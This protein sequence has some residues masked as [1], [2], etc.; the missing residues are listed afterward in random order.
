MCV[1]DT[2]YRDGLTAGPHYF[3]NPIG[4]L[5]I[6]TIGT[7]QAEIGGVGGDW[8]IYY[9]GKNVNTDAKLY[10]GVDFYDYTMTKPSDQYANDVVLAFDLRKPAFDYWT[11]DSGGQ[12]L[13]TVDGTITK[14]NFT[15]R[16]VGSH[17]LRIE[18]NDPNPCY[19]YLDSGATAWDVTKWGSE[20]TIPTLNFYACFIQY[21]GTPKVY[22]SDNTNA[23]KTDYYWCDITPNNLAVWEHHSIPIGP[24]WGN[25]EA[26]LIDKWGSVSGS[27]APYPQWSHI[28]TIEFVFD[29]SGP[30][31]DIRIDDLH[32]SGKCVREAVHTA[33]VTAY[34]EYQHVILSRTPLDDSAVAADDSGMAGQLCHAELLRRINPPRYFSC[35]VPFKPYLKPGECFTV[36]AGKTTAGAYK[37]S[38]V[39]FRVVE[40]THRVTQGFQPQT[41]LVMT[42]DVLNS[43]P[44]GAVNARGVLNEYLLEN[45]KKATDM[46]GGEVD[47]LIPHLRKTY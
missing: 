38:G 43:F 19:I 29:V 15:A 26:T 3:V 6:K 31:D 8:G 17:S 12:A 28:D 16:V 4:Q 22:L 9:N 46:Q 45:N 44:L 13:W 41:S 34:N 27:G 10:E 24:Y 18:P 30:G 33:S 11:E 42:D 1:L 39:D 47:L 25:A 7:Q 37:L 40:Y 35:T 32:F 23:R 14:S 21:A 2:S 36:Y 5:R 20:R